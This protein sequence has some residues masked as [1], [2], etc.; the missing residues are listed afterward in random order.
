MND[1]SHIL[2]FKRSREEKKTSKRINKK[3]IRSLSMKDTHSTRFDRSC[4]SYF[5]KIISFSITSP[6]M[7]C[8][9]VTWSAFAYV[10]M[11]KS[12]HSQVPWLCCF[13]VPRMVFLL[14]CLAISFPSFSFSLKYY[15]GP[16]C[17]LLK[18]TLS[19]PVLLH[20]YWLPLFF[21]SAILVFVFYGT[22]NKLRNRFIS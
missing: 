10:N 11:T 13:P 17:S 3:F 4:P 1:M 20:G 12:S 9:L 16:L 21:M 14:L 8:V 2:A 15:R 6:L 7:P 18:K 22:H 5:S 19:I